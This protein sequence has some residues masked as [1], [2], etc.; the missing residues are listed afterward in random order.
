MLCYLNKVYLAYFG[1]I[2]GSV[3]CT[4]LVWC[5]KSSHGICMHSYI[6]VC[7]YF[8]C[9]FGAIILCV[10]FG[11]NSDCDC[12]D[13]CYSQ[14]TKSSGASCFYSYFFELCTRNILLDL[15]EY[16]DLYAM[17]GKT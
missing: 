3:L 14:T 11:A 4:C 10:D 17:L 13:C 6:F 1:L 9:N 7:I 16:F 8:V 5:R 12:E 15:H 2:Y